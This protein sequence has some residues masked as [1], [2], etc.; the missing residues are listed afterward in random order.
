VVG[1]GVADG[2]SAWK[3]HGYN[4]GLIARQLMTNCKLF[5]KYTKPFDILDRAWLKL[6]DGKEVEAGSTTA[7]IVRLH[8]KAIRVCNIG[9]SGIIVLRKGNIVFR[10]TKLEH[11][12]HMPFQLAV[13]PDHLSE[14][15]VSDPVDSCVVEKFTGQKGDVIV[16]ASD[17]I[18]DNMNDEHLLGQLKG[19]RNMEEYAVHLMKIA[20][21]HSWKPDDITIIC[22]K[23]DEMKEDDINREE[24]GNSMRVQNKIK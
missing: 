1:L 15:G 6:R 13:I 23:I 16:V 21:S 4:S 20:V 10:A 17:G 22:A 24:I 18:W 7:C 3:H 14:I 2:I 11:E 12:R 19:A 8:K 5:G 9:D